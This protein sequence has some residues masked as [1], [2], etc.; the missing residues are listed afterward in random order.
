M[1][2]YL[3][4]LRFTAPVHFGDSLSAAS[5]SGSEMAFC[6]DR[7]FSAL[8]CTMAKAD[9][10]APS[11]LCGQA[12]QG[13]LK[14]SD[15]FP[16][17]GEKLYLPRPCLE[18]TARRDS[19]ASQRKEMKKLMYLPLSNYAAFIRSLSGGAELNA[20]SLQ[21]SFGQ[22]TVQMRACVQAGKDAAP[23]AVGQFWFDADCGLYF[24]V[25]AQELSLFKEIHTAI[26]LLG[27]SGIGGKI[28]SGLGGFELV[29]AVPIGAFGACGKL[30]EK[31]LTRKSADV[32]I[33]LT[34]ALPRDDE[35]DLAM[36]GALFQLMRRSG[37]V[38]S[39]GANGPLKKQEQ[40]FFK[41]GST[42]RHLFD[43]DVY[44]VAPQGC[45]H[46]VYRYGMPL[47]LG[48]DLK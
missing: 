10:E 42:F 16:W 47:F 3:F 31:A 37:F 29:Q 21:G 6:A 23:Y 2:Y 15:A 36:D 33:S 13:R 39:S 34:T 25:G 40:F 43:G 28:S 4:K 17:R 45:S 38:Q 35:L 7:L 48:V 14:L 41:A 8:C 26:Q 18:A 9:P 19:D 32:W 20:D 27:Q 12:R 24:V 22:K 44:D 46:P 30:L 11:R 5:L 1:V